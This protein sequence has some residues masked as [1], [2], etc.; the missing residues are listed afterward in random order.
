MRRPVAPA[1]RAVTSVSGYT[2]PSFIGGVSMAM[3]STPATDAGITFMSTLEGY[4]A[5]PPGTYTAALLI[6]V[7]F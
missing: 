3:R 4:I 1:S 7:I 2:L 6:G 5:V